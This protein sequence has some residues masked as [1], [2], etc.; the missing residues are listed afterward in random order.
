MRCVNS[1]PK[2]DD[3]EII[4]IDDNSDPEIVDFENFPFKN[5]A[6]IRIILDKSDKCAGHARNLGLE[7][8]QGKWII[9][10]DADDFFM[11]PFNKI[12][13]KYKNSEYDIIYCNAC[14][15]DSEFYINAGRV[16]HLNSYIETYR[17]NQKKGELDLRYRFGEPW[18]KIIKNFLIHNN[19]I[20]F[21]EVVNHNDTKFS[22]MAGYYAKN[23]HVDPISIYCVTCREKSLSKLDSEEIKLNRIKIFAEANKFFEKHNITVISNAGMNQ[24]YNL[25]R[26]NKDTYN[27][28][29]KI[30]IE[31]GYTPNEIRS[32]LI[33]VFIEKLKTRTKK[34]GKKLIKKLLFLD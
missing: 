30:L 12:L 18:C 1:I 11:P 4:I 17:E 19:K 14:S 31:L 34:Y 32:E 26:E 23:I 2:R 33:K 9:F 10:A 7:I 8:A 25:R 15:L 29:Y 20:K 5:E 28:G 21:D 24:L 16:N 3:L 27:K 13:D 22:Y 6:N